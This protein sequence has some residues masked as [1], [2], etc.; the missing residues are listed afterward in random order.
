MLELAPL[1]FVW[2]VLAM[3]LL[4]FGAGLVVLVVVNRQLSRNLSDV[5]DASAH[6]I[7]AVGDSVCGI[8]SKSNAECARQLGNLGESMQ[9]VIDIQ[10]RQVT[11][12]YHRNAA[13]TH[14]LVVGSGKLDRTVADMILTGSPVA[15]IVTRPGQHILPKTRVQEASAATRHRS[16]RF[17]KDLK[18]AAQKDRDEQQDGQPAAVSE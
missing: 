18:R 4:G 11:E 9:A 2:L 17:Q 10:Q 7:Q 14:M 3:L 8:M 1:T 16:V 5:C 13:L 6:Q 12:T 15:S